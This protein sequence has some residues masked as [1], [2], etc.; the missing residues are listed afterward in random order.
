M[1]AFL[2]QS[3]MLQTFVDMPQT[4]VVLP[5][6]ALKV[7]TGLIWIFSKIIKHLLC[8][9]YTQSKYVRKIYRKQLS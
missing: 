2:S 3:W 6:I 5:V 7:F 1:L 9:F 4:G 8:L